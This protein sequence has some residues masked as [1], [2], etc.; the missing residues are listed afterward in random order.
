VLNREQDANRAFAQQE[1]DDEVVE[2]DEDG[3]VHSRGNTPQYKKKVVLID[4]EGEFLS[5][6]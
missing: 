5:A 2:V 1:A 6:P 4:A 3:N